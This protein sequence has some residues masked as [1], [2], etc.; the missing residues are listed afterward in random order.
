VSAPVISYVPF[1]E[2]IS[3]LRLDGLDTE[4]ARLD[5]LIHKVAWTTG[6]ELMGELGREMRKLQQEHGSKLSAETC[7]KMEAAFNIVRRVWPRF[8]R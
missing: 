6:S 7:T 5:Y 1:D 3:C 4:A 8:P 2:L